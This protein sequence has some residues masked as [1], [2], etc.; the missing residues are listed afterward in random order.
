M[1]KV[2]RLTIKMSNF[3]YQYNICV[4]THASSA[5]YIYLENY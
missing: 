3:A 2:S 4:Y 5:H 1:L